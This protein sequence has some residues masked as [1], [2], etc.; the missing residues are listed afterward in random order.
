MPKKSIFRSVAISVAISVAMACPLLASEPPDPLKSPEGIPATDSEMWREQ[1]RPGTLKVFRDQVYGERPVAKPPDFKAVVV[2]QQPDALDGT[3]TLK[4][5]EFSY[6][7][8]GGKGKFH[9]VL[10]TPNAAQR[11][12][13]A[14][15]LINFIDP[16]PSLERNIKGFWPVQEIIARGYATM[17]FNFNEVDP[18][19]VDGYNGG[20]RAIYSKLPLANNA[21]ASLSAWGWGASRIFDYLETDK[22]IDSSHVAIIGHSRAGKAAVW[23]GAEDERFALVISNNSGCGGASLARGK[24]GE[25]VADI[26]TRFAYWFCENYRQYANNEDALPIDQHQLLGLIAPRLL[27]VASATEDQWAA[28]KNEFKSCV[29]AGPVYRLFGK[30]GLESDTMPPPDQSMSGGSIG[31]HMRSGKHDLA[32]SDW[33]HYMDFADKNWGKPGK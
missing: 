28:P 31:Y 27:Y 14:F 24:E 16:D 21:W 1:V 11:P 2:R 32:P 29:L 22:S 15:V 10:L 19:R 9:A 17:S 30:K 20:V 6:S 7:G 25:K 12:S 5:I 23:C 4:E 33:Q 26:T 13:P 3:A 18:D 8:P